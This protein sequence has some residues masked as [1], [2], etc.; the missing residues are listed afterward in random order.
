MCPNMEVSHARQPRSS[1]VVL[2]LR[3]MPKLNTALPFLGWVGCGSMGRYFNRYSVTRHIII[4]TYLRCPIHGSPASPDVLE[5]GDLGRDLLS[6]TLPKGQAPDLPGKQHDTGAAD[7]Q[8]QDSMS[9]H[10]KHKQIELPK[11]RIQTRVQ[12]RAI[13]RTA[14]VSSATLTKAKRRKR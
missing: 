2:Y 9:K 8:G 6:V 10:T 13:A 1:Y 4:S 5:V 3:H 7:Q 11:T 14:T 12:A